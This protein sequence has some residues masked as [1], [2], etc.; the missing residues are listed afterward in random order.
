MWEVFADGQIPYQGSTAK[1]I[2]EFLK[3]G[4][5]LNSPLS[6]DKDVYSWMTACWEE[7]PTKR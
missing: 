5:R 1:E 3:S 2:I 4:N 6:A 7:N